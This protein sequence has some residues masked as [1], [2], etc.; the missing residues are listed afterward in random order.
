M[1]GSCA[2]LLAKGT[3]TRIT[4][5]S[6]QMTGP[7][8]R[9]FFCHPTTVIKMT[10]L[11]QMSEIQQSGTK[12][13]RGLGESGGPPRRIL[14]PPAHPKTQLRALSLPSVPP[15]CSF[16]PRPHTADAPPRSLPRPCRTS[17]V[18]PRIRPRSRY[19]PLSADVVHCVHH[20]RQVF[21]QMSLPKKLRFTLFTL[22]Q[23]R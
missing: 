18:P 1:F 15:L 3:P 7:T 12:R 9:T 20:A 5:S 4:K 14:T 16:C 2:Y 11:I 8:V 23:T 6:E 17:V 19:P 13:K 21:A 10:G 22:K